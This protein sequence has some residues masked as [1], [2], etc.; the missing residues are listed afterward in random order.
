MIKETCLQIV[1]IEQRLAS[2]QISRTAR[3][4]RIQSIDELLN[5]FEL[6]NL[7]EEMEIP[8]ELEG[9]VRAFVASESHPVAAR[10]NTEISI[11]DWMEA[12][13]DVQDTLMVPFEDDFE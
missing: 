4:R 5:E 2:E 7:A 6:L 11:T 13:Y 9:K 1:D 3:R 10:P 12:L 8:I